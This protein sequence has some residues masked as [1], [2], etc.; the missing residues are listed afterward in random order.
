[1]T[2]GCVTRSITSG[3]DLTGPRVHPGRRR[4]RRYYVHRDRERVD[5]ATSPRRTSAVAGPAG[6]HEQD[7][8][9]GHADRR[10][11]DDDRGRDHRDVHRVDRAALAE[12]HR[13]GLHERGDDRRAASPQANY[14]SGSQFTGLV[15]GTS[16]YV[17]ITAISSSAAYGPATSARLG[18]P[19]WRPSSSPPRRSPRS[20]RRRR[21]P[22]SSR[23]RSPARRTPLAARPTRRPRAP[24][25]R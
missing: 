12:L 2:T 18:A 1:M 23:S 24:T 6:R 19:R 17:T 8:L 13:D 25:R 4:A 16:Y 15:Q 21:P 3:S 14:T 11:V 7:Q 9:P 10:V 20:R 22:G 5:R